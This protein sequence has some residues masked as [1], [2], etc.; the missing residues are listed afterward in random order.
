MNVAWTARVEWIG[1][2]FSSVEVLRVYTTTVRHLEK[3]QG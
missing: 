3:C 1:L 2:D